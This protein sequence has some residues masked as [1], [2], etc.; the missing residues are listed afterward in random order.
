M[1]EIL[2]KSGPIGAGKF[3][4]KPQVKVLLNGNKHSSICSPSSAHQYRNNSMCRAPPVQ[5]EQHMHLKEQLYA[6]YS[7]Y[8]KQ[9]FNRNEKQG[10]EA[11][12]S[13]A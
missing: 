1:P 13:N 5:R 11:R 2:T 7:D 6:Q 10:K 4:H 12:T 8:Q 9:H 3:H